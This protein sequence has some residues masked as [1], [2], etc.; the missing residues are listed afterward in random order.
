VN[1]KDYL[2]RVKKIDRL[3]ENKIAEAMHWKTVATGTSTNSEGERVQSSGSKQKMADA[4]ARYVDIEAEINEEIDRLADV[5]R[6]I[7]LTIEVLPV[8]EYDMLYQVYVNCK[9]LQDVATD[10]DKS[11]SWATTIHGRALAHLQKIL[12][13]RE[14]DA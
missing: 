6:E 11:Y 8:D 9:E 3:I 10:M 13:E 7:V 14:K 12:D 4:V 1:A 5:R 2:Q